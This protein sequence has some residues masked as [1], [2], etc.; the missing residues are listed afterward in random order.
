MLKTSHLRIRSRAILRRVL[1]VSAQF[2]P[3]S[4][5]FTGSSLTRSS[6]SMIMVLTLTSR[7]PICHSNQMVIIP[8]ITWE[9]LIWLWHL[10]INP[11]RI[12]RK[13]RLSD[14]FHLSICRSMNITQPTIYQNTV[15]KFTL[16][17]IL[18]ISFKTKYLECTALI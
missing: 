11:S 15:K 14:I 4:F 7:I 6:L 3:S 10:T 1:E 5:F 16:R 13:Q 9:N 8:H 12:W 18:R 17:T 2:Y